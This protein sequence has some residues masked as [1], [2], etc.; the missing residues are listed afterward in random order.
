MYMTG[1]D[2]PK[3]G[4]LPKASEAAA[5]KG[6]EAVAA[7][8]EL[9]GPPAPKAMFEES[10][11][12]KVVEKVKRKRRRRKRKDPEDGSED[13][14][15][16]EAEKALSDTEKEVDKVAE[17]LAGAAADV[18]IEDGEGGPTVKLDVDFKKMAGRKFVQHFTPDVKGF[19]VRILDE[20]GKPKVERALSRKVVAGQIAYYYI[21]DD[22]REVA[23]EVPK[24]GRGEIVMRPQDYELMTPE[25]IHL[26][27]QHEMR[28]AAAH[29]VPRA[30][31][32]NASEDPGIVPAPRRVSTG[33][34]RGGYGS[35]AGYG[36]SRPSPR[37]VSEA[38]SPFA[39][40]AMIEDDSVTLPEILK[41]DMEVVREDVAA[42]QSPTGHSFLRIYSKTVLEK[43][44]H[45]PQIFY[46]F[47]G[48]GTGKDGAARSLELEARVDR[49]AKA[50]INA[51]FVVPQPAKTSNYKAKWDYLADGAFSKLAKADR[52]KF[53]KGEVKTYAYFSSGGYRAVS[54]AL[55]SG[56]VF[57]AIV[58][59]DGFF[60]D[61]KRPINGP[62]KDYAKANPGRLM[63]FGGSRT[64]KQ[65]QA[66]KDAVGEGAVFV[67]A[68]GHGGIFSKEI[69]RSMRFAMGDI[70]PKVAKSPSL[71]DYASGDWSKIKG[72]FEGVSSYVAGIANS[73]LDRIPRRHI[74]PKHCN[75]YT[76]DAMLTIRRSLGLPEPNWVRY[77]G[78]RKGERTTYPAF[79]PEAPVTGLVRGKYFSEIANNPSL[80]AAFSKGLRAG[81]CL[82]GN[83]PSSYTRN[84]FDMQKIGFKAGEQNDFSRNKYGGSKSRR[85]WAA[86]TGRNKRGEP[87]IVDNWF[88][89]HKGRPLTLRQWLLKFANSKKG[90]YRRMMVS[91]KRG[92]SD[93]E[94]A[95]VKESASYKSY[96]ARYGIKDS[97]GN[98]S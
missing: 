86:V 42:E 6:A 85:H 16:A 87:L 48:D 33:T 70:V 66:I 78:R 80:L 31:R 53:A 37:R 47:P 95:R 26:A 4:E 34:Y 68:K 67:E 30:A 8:K 23:F 82:F 9:M 7:D 38:T 1:I 57:D 73:V 43:S 60:K 92:I 19:T 97:P 21:A 29:V 10:G 94:M 41:G 45:P 46:V 91:V 76:E 90:S 89:A 2:G 13:E 25:Q 39:P 27:M 96:A 64:R 81:D 74:K 88:N 75:K 24:G 79:A 56:F 36:G 22:G 69:D 18:K 40:R 72:A 71:R 20:E 49:Y 17:N 83:N 63:M 3:K 84:G 52:D 65:A 12:G 98:V 14:G 15:K 58:G 77:Y 62:L 32:K 44:K 54:H 61:A 59:C 35:R 11:V 55:K 28:K 5:G 51:V 93:S 50:G